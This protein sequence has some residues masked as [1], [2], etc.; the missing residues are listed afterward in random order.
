[1]QQI[2]L[3]HKVWIGHNDDIRHLLTPAQNDPVFFH[4]VLVNYFFLKD[5]LS[6]T[7]CS[8]S[9]F[10]DKWM[11]VLRVLHRRKWH[12][13]EESHNEFERKAGNT[14]KSLTSAF[15]KLGAFCVQMEPDAVGTINTY[16]S[17]SLSSRGLQP[18][19]KN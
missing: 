19:R 3:R 13:P 1:M 5:I 14:Y 6:F 10:V 8:F 4:R 7:P 17:L 18:C 16:K 2:L 11:A 9:I 15:I 12:L